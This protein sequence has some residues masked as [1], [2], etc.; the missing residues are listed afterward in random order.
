M[1]MPRT[2][3]SSAFP[4]RLGI[5][6]FRSDALRGT[7]ATA[8]RLTVKVAAKETQVVTAVDEMVR[9]EGYALADADE[10]MLSRWS[11]ATYDLTTAAKLSEL[12][13]ARIKATAAERRLADIDEEVGRISEE[14]G[15]IRQNLGAVPSQSKLATNYMRDM[16]DQEDALASL[17][18]QRKKADAQ[19]KQYGDSVGAI[20]RA[21]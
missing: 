12:A 5:R 9:L 15:R 16:K 4:E 6:D 11:S 1:E 18:T 21:F 8:R 13:L 20:V 14:Q 2:Y 3:R 19:L 17:R 7:T 10:T